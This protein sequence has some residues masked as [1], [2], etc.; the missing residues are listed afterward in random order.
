MLKSLEYKEFLKYKLRTSS[1]DE[2][3]KKFE[4]LIDLCEE[5]E[6]KEEKLDKYYES[7]MEQSSFRAEVIEYILQACNDKDPRYTETKEL[8][9]EINQIVENSYVEL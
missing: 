2:I 1:L 7:S 8:I 9:K 4:E 5:L 6:L 3:E